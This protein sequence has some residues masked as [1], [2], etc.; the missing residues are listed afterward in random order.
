MTARTNALED[1]L[2][3]RILVL[4]GAMGSMVQG[5][6]LAE[7]DFRGERFADRIDSIAGESIREIAKTNAG[8]VGRRDFTELRRCDAAHEVAHELAGRTV[9]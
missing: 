1:A 8:L 3:R 5:Y 7:A 4:D 2:Q 9:V 6:G